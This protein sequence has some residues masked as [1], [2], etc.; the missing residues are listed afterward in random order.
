ME[1][2]Q[3]MEDEEVATAKTEA[4]QGGED[5]SAELFAWGKQWCYW[6]KS[7]LMPTEEEFLPSP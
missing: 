4:A 1:E 3:C 5:K 2:L 7:E 6:G